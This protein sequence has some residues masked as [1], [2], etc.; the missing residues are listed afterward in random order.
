MRAI[1]HSNYVTYLA[2]KL[3][4]CKGKNESDSSWNFRVLYSAISLNM[5]ASLY[6]YDEDS[7]QSVGNE[8][9]VSMQHVRTRGI[10]LIESY[11]DLYRT[12]MTQLNL[13]SE[14][15]AES[16]RDIY[17]QTGYILHKANYLTAP[18]AICAK[19]EDIY[20]LRGTSPWNVE[21]MSGLGCYAYTV[22]D[23]SVEDVWR[24][25]RIENTEIS[26][27]WK[28]FLHNCQWRELNELPTEVEYINY[29]RKSGEQYW[30]SNAPKSGLSMYRDKSIGEKK[31]G[32]IQVAAGQIL[33]SVLPVWQVDNKEYLR[34]SLA[35]QNAAAKN[36][37]VRIKSASSISH[38][39]LSYLLP[40]CEQNFL[41]LFSW[42]SE[43]ISRWK[44]TVVTELLP[45][46][47]QL[48]KNL[49]FNIMEE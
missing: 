13:C 29:S 23:T 17:M 37:T 2:Q 27:W 32:L 39:Q 31:Y 46:F 18:T 8:Q 10:E 49:C 24:M 44:R 20:F 16:I 11:R 25:F 38:I 36:P 7:G 3:H 6:D 28:Q 48:F 33:T 43:G 1:T 42:P 41:E 4:I 40:P 22:T 15:L 12:A 9:M 19:Y 5:L 21:Y 34:I 30:L 47:K 35:L 45:I 14:K 26:V